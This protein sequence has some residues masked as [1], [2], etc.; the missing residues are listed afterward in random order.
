MKKKI[1]SSNEITDIVN[2]YQNEA[3]GIESLAKEYGVGKLKI[4]SI[5]EEYGIQFKKRGGQVVIG[6]SSEIERT[7]VVKYVSSDLNKKLVAVCKK[8]GKRF[9]DVNNISG[10]LTSHILSEYGNVPIPTNTYQRKKYEIE[11]GHKWFEEY[12]DIVSDDVEPIKKCPYCDWETTDVNNLSGQ[13]QVHLYEKHGLIIDDYLSEFP[14][15]LPYFNIHKTYQDRLEE[16]SDDNNY[17]ICEECGEKM[18]FLTNTHL[19]KHGMTSMEYKIKYPNKKILSNKLYDLFSEQYRKANI[20]MKPKWTS[21]GEIEVKEF[22]ESLGFNVEKSRNRKLL[23]GKEIDIIIPELTL[24]IEYN[25]LFWHTE[26]KGKGFNY[27]LNKTIACNQIGY[28]LIHLFEDEWSTKK[29]LIKHKL[30]HILGVSDGIKI[31]AR[32]CEIK[33]INNN[34]KSTFLNKFHIQG[35]DKSSINIG[36]YYD[37]ILVGVMTFNSNRVMTTN[38]NVGEFELS[39]FAIDYSYIISGLASKMLKFFI[40]TYN[41]NKIISFADRRWTVSKDNNMYTKLGF[42]LKNISKPNYWYYNSKIDRQKRFHKF[43]FGKSG[44]KRKYP[45]LDFSKTEKE[46]TQELGYDRIWDCGLFKY[47]LVI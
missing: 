16:L 45:N 43:G 3:I 20:D 18:K 44:L 4:R 6:N 33:V 9:N 31:G 1:L 42:K 40:N 35:N 38:I 17:V 30:K 29:D 34:E 7:K 46:L 23:V 27:H 37:N 32:K 8:T 15:D 47:E 13:F 14:D 39:R 41:A 25:G 28:N 11:Y 12:F 36:A 5:L 26:N 2:K 21:S 22:V 24:G 10:N 19:A